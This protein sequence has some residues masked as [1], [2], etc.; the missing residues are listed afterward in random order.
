MS[1][2]NACITPYVSIFGRRGIT[3]EEAIAEGYDD[4]VE[5]LFPELERTGYVL[6]EEQKQRIRGIIM[7]TVSNMATVIS[8]GECLDTC[9]GL[10]DALCGR[11]LHVDDNNYVEFYRGT[12]W[13]MESCMRWL[14]EDDA[15]KKYEPIFA[16]ILRESCT[17]KFMVNET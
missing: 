9:V 8:P 2:D 3:A 4:I 6:T 16:E 5:T 10:A 11:H 13:A 1:T 15:N 12:D 17:K 7:Y 14:F